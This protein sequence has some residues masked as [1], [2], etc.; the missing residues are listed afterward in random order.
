MQDQHGG[1]A[2]P[3][4]GGE[5][6]PVRIWRGDAAGRYQTY[7]VPRLRNQTVL[8]V[9]TWVQ[10]HLEPTLAYRFACRVGM[11]GSC[12]MSVNGR[13]RWTCRTHT[14]AVAGRASLEIGPL[15]NLPVIRDLVVDMTPFF[16]KWQ[17]A[18]ARFEGRLTRR[19]APLPVR[20]DSPARSE[21]D[22]AIECINCGVCH[23]ACEVVAWDPT[24]VGPAALNRAWSL[25]QDERHADKATLWVAVGGDGGTFGC[26]SHGACS[27]HCPVGLDPSRSI[28]GL[29][30][31]AARQG[32][33]E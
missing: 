28:A 32:A 22:L 23:A 33:D 10:R 25:T 9:V 20:P 21:A 8:D 31:W 26:H 6:M 12:A 14:A 24:Y 27:E 19:D 2:E 11:C 7:R 5:F 13:P 15:R 16:E 3:G 29:K 17:R 30:R 4:Q 18:Q 1:P